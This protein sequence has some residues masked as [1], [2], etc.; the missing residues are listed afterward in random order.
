MTDRIKFNVGGQLFETTRSTI[1]KYPDSVLATHISPP[2]KPDADGIYFLD[3]DPNVFGALLGYYRS[4]G[5]ERPPNVSTSLWKA[6]LDYWGIPAPTEESPSIMWP[7][8][9]DFIESWR[10]LGKHP[11]WDRIQKAV[12]IAKHEQINY[13]VFPIMAQKV[14]AG[15]FFEFLTE[16]ET[17]KEIKSIQKAIAFHFDTPT[18][19]IREIK[20]DQGKLVA[21]DLP[22]I[23]IWYD[24]CNRW[25]DDAV[26]R[27]GGDE[28]MRVVIGHFSARPTGDVI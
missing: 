28:Y 8:K 24:R 2:W 15:R 20:I 23:N 9:P 19:E 12:N 18:I 11:M 21:P 27:R 22:K 17:A 6:E 3:R 25:Y 26:Y 4:N 1:L 10:I 5:L 16:T 13:V 7:Y 14:V